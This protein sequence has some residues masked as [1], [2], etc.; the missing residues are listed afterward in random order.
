MHLVERLSSKARLTPD[1]GQPVASVP[2]GGQYPIHLFS[3]PTVWLSF[4]CASLDKSCCHPCSYWHPPKPTGVC[5]I[6]V[7]GGSDFETFVV[8]GSVPLLCCSC[9]CQ[10]LLLSWWSGQHPRLCP[11]HSPHS[12]S[13]RNH[14]RSLM[15]PTNSCLRG[16]SHCGQRSTWWVLLMGWNALSPWFGSGCCRSFVCCGGTASVTSVVKQT[17]KSNTTVTKTKV[18]RHQSNT[19]VTLGG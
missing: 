10:S 3:F 6:V 17:K 16:A 7:D 9:P 15:S 5:V 2:I 18:E 4:S 1:R 14:Q 19:A 8:T 13:H 12:P 11:S